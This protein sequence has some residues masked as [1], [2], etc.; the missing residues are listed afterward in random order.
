MDYLRNV[1]RHL[2][3]P[4]TSH[5]RPMLVDIIS[6]FE[7][8]DNLIRSVANG[9]LDGFTETIMARVDA[10]IK[11][12]EDRMSAIEDKI[13]AIEG[14]LN[15]IAADVPLIVQGVGAL[16]A[17]IAT[18]QGE[19]VAAGTPISPTAQAALD[20]MVATSANVKTALDGLATSLAPVAPAPAA[21]S[22][23]ATAAAAADTPAPTSGTAAPATAAPAPDAAAPA[24][25]P[26]TTPA[27]PPA[28]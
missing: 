18:L 4:S 20:S 6:V 23:A 12:G 2:E 26:A 8:Y 28:S 17:Q 21:P 24:A 25:A 16:Q 13:T 1:R 10:A 9:E 11:T 7:N 3:S 22:P 27:T 5:L 19:L 15:G 14:T